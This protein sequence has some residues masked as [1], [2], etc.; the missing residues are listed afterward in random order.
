MNHTQ[1]R[2]RIRRIVLFLL[3]PILLGY[4]IVAY[5]IMPQFWLHHEQHPALD[6]IPTTA[7]N[8]D[9]I[10]ADALNVGFVGSKQKLIQ[11]FIAAGWQPADA[12]TF[13]SS[14]AIVG[15]VLLR[16]PDPKAPVSNLYLWGRIEDLAFEQEVGKSAKQ[17]HHVRLW[18]APDMIEG[19]TVWIGAATFDMG[20]ELSHTTAQITHRIDSDIDQERDK[21]MTDIQNTGQVQRVFQATGVGATLNGRNAGGDRYY[22]D[23]ERTVAVLKP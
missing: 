18:Q 10:R 14:V 7:F 17:R 6:A 15:S 22:T 9:N 12:L 23:G 19:Q 21:L 20:V 5:L 3:L 13:R 8:A 16:E 1:K 11:T 2:H 4:G